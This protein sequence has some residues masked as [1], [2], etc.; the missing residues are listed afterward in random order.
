MGSCSYIKTAAWS[1]ILSFNLGCIRSSIQLSNS[2]FMHVCS[3]S[4]CFHQCSIRPA[5]AVSSLTHFGVRCCRVCLG[6]PSRANP[7][8]FRFI[9]HL[10]SRPISG[11]SSS[12]VP[13]RETLH[14]IETQTVV[15]MCRSWRIVTTPRFWAA[16]VLGPSET[17]APR[18]TTLNPEP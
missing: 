6:L 9:L 17:E 10:R 7:I 11:G 2:G 13:T 1:L 8:V 4:W 3:G 5:L 15:L 18:P 14:I 12:T 16:Q